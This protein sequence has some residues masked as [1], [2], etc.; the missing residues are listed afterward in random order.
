[1]ELREPRERVSPK[2]RLM[3]FCTDALRGVPC[4]VRGIHADEQQLPVADRGEVRA[5]ATETSL[6]RLEGAG[7]TV[8]THRDVP[9]NDGGI[10]LGQILVGS[11]S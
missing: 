10:A 5:R 3:W 1:M 4:S 6:D 7:F 9:P 11:T 2:A 8:L